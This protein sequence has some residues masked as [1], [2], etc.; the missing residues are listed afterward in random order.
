[1]RSC[2]C[3]STLQKSLL[4]SL[5]VSVLLLFSIKIQTHANDWINIFILRA[6]N[7][8]KMTT[9]LKCLMKCFIQEKKFIHHSMEEEYGITSPS[10]LM[11]KMSTAKAESPQRRKTW[12][13]L[14]ICVRLEKK[15][16]RNSYAVF[17]VQ[18]KISSIENL[19]LFMFKT[20]RCVNSICTIEISRWIFFPCVRTLFIGC[21]RKRH[22][23]FL[24]VCVWLVRRLIMIF[25]LFTTQYQR[26]FG[27]SASKPGFFFC[28]VLFGSCSVEST[29]FSLS[30]HVLFVLFYTFLWFEWNFICTRCVIKWRWLVPYHAEKT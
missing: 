20:N 11:D 4:E 2:V 30:L 17:K 1:M 10:S 25:Y 3:L 9:I 29:F 7:A 13:L 24:C 8:P 27:L 14:V 18:R 5:F 15:S 22:Y 6:N 16:V 21:F 23:F 12:F 28:S 26:S 19:L